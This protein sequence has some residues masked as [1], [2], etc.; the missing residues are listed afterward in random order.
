MQRGCKRFKGVPKKAAN[1]VQGL[2]KGCEKNSRSSRASKV[3]KNFDGWL[4]GK[5]NGT[6][7]L[8]GGGW[9]LRKATYFVFIYI[10]IY[11]K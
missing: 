3:R 10:Y 1:G 9:Y 11:T 8:P 4:K 6:F 5:L 7:K 2:L